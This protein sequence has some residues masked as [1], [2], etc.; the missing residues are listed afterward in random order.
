VAVLLAAKSEATVVS[1]LARA[2]PW[3][4]DES[5]FVTE[6]QSGSESAFD[7]LVTHYHAPVFNLVYRMLGNHADAA[8]VTQEVFLKAFRGIRGFRQ[9]SSLK[10]WLFSIAIRE[11]LNL[12]RWWSRHL[13]PLISLEPDPAAEE[14]APAMQLEA[15]DLS[16]FEQAAAHEEQL[17]VQQALARVPEVFRG[18][19]VLRDLEGLSYEEVAEILE[20]SVGTVKSRIVRGRRLLRQALKEWVEDSARRADS[21][22]DSESLFSR[23]AV[24]HAGRPRSLRGGAL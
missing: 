7:W 24:P 19:V 23:P 4:Q 5:E 1:E 11:A 13:R 14:P 22:D 3:S 18:A 2:L 16:P 17:A 6:L 20:I 9:G 21:K 15:H 10:T 8:D 12:R